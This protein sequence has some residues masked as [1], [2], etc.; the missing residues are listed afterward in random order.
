MLV[1]KV[2]GCVNHFKKFTTMKIIFNGEETSIA[3]IGMGDT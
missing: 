1:E 2:K 3:I